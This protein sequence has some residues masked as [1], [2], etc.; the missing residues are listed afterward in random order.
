M[1]LC[2]A[3]SVPARI[4][5]A[6]L[7]VAAFA[8]P[9]SAQTGWTYRYK[10]DTGSGRV[11]V[12][13]ENARREL[14]AQSNGPLGG[15]V[16]IWKR[17]GR[18]RLMLDP[19]SRTYFDVI[20]RRAK[21]NVSGATMP[22]LTADKPFR[23]ESAG[24]VKIETTPSRRT[25]QVGDYECWPLRVD[26]S[27]TLTLSLEGAAA[28]FPARVEAVE[29]IC[30]IDWANPPPLPFGHAMALTSTHPEVDR[31][32]AARLAEL[33]GI[34]VA[35]VVKVT[36]RIEGGEQTSATSALMLADIREVPVSSTRFSVPDGYRLIDAIAPPSRR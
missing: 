31:V 7:V 29:E 8:V 27:Y 14:D 25:Q 22:I 18:D 33:K 20:A 5:I 17:G 36:R 11:W 16:E 9:A 19:V 13:G 30:V 21:G 2:V 35:R 12:S 34:A 6:G 1:E 15:F 24:A 10:S 32:L 26:F 28:T 23:V 3:E 4:L